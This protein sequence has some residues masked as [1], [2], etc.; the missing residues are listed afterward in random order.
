MEAIYSSIIVAFGVTLWASW[1]LMKTGVSWWEIG[2]ILT[3]VLVSGMIFNYLWPFS[4]V[5]G[6]IVWLI[7]AVIFCFWGG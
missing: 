3:G 5:S 2:L 7:I 6:Q 1:Q 4:F